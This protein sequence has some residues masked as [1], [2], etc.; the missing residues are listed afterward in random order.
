VYFNKYNYKLL[1]YIY[2]NPDVAEG[3][4]RKKFSSDVSWVLIG[5]V[6]EQYIGGKNPDGS[7]LSFEELPYST[8]YETEYFTLP[9]GQ[10]YI[11]DRHWD[12]WKWLV[13]LVISSIALLISIYNIFI[14]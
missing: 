7:F 8:T 2:S 10:A 14:K 3:K 13:P 5:F 12:R 6:K 1:R 9:K 11:E 4:L